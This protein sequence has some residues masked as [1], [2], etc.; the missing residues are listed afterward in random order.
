MLAVKI[1]WKKNNNSQLLIQVLVCSIPGLRLPRLLL[2]QNHPRFHGTGRGFHQGRRHRREEVSLIWDWYVQWHFLINVFFIFQHLRHQVWRREL[3][4]ATRLQVPAEH[5][6]RGRGH[7]RLAVLHHNRKDA[8]VTK[9]MV[10][11]TKPHNTFNI[12]CLSCRL[13]GMHV[14]FGRVVDSESERV[15][16]K[17]EGFGTQGGNPTANVVIAKCA[18]Q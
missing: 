18:C 13:D 3:R 17:I 2:P 1:R 15:V 4:V 9:I 6:Q 8:L 14:V 12:V 10:S 11:I 7:Q 16:D 5:G